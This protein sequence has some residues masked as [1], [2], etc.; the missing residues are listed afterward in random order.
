[1]SRSQLFA[2]AS[3]RIPGATLTLEVGRA[4]AIPLATYNAFAG[5]DP[6][7]ALWEGALGI[8]FGMGR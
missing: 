5:R 3:V 4:G 8:R 1:M 7:A 2:D 6:G